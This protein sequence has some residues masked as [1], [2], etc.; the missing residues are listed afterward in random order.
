MPDWPRHGR[1]MN[2]SHP[3]TGP[4]MLTLQGLAREQETAE[5]GLLPARLRLATW[6]K[7]RLPVRDRLEAAITLC[8]RYSAMAHCAPRLFGQALLRCSSQER[9]GRERRGKCR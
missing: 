8:L 4:R 3:L 6:T 7:G 1:P 5:R 9:R 2:G